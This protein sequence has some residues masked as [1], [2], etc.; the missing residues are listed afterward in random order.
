[1][2]RAASPALALAQRLQQLGE[3]APRPWRLR[4][5]S[6]SAEP[7][8]S[9]LRRPCREAFTICTG[10]ALEAVFHRS[11]A[12][13]STT[14]RTAVSAQIHRSPPANLQATALRPSESRPG[15]KVRTRGALEQVP[16]DPT[17]YRFL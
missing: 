17:I 5:P 2:A 14:L 12:R 3:G 10:T 16:V 7:G 13:P 1:V 11:G 9:M 8:W 4:I 6:L 15:D